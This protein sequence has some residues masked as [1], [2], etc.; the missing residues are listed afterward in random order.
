MGQKTAS[1]REIN[2]HSYESG[3]NLLQKS[4]YIKWLKMACVA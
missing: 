3:F 1:G 4:G 2:E